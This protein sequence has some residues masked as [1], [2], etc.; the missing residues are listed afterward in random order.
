VGARTGALDPQTG[1]VYLPAAKFKPPTAAFPFPS[2]IE[3][4]FVTLVIAPK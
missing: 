1:R 2:A 3:G 4:T